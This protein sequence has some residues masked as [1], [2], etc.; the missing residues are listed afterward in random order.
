MT[1]VAVV[2]RWFLRLPMTIEA[3]FMTIFAAE[4]RNGPK[5][6]AFNMLERDVRLNRSRQRHCSAI[7][8]EVA[9]RANVSG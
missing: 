3:S 4:P 8:C 6:V 5:G 2:M 9:G 1:A 7:V